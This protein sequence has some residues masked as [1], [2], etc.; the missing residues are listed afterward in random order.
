MGK[1]NKRKKLMKSK[2]LILSFVLICELNIYNNLV[3]SANHGSEKNLN[4]NKISYRKLT[5]KDIENIHNGSLYLENGTLDILLLK[6]NF[7][8]PNADNDNDGLKNDEEINIKIINGKEYINYISHPMLEDTDGDGINDNKDKEKL[9][10]NISERDMILFQE[11]CYRNDDYIDEV[12]TPNN[13]SL[14]LYKGREE[15]RL[16]NNELSFYWKRIKSWHESNGFDAVLFEY[17]NKK[18]PFLNNEAVHVLAIRGTEGNSDYGSDASIFLGQWPSQANSAIN[19][20]DEFDKFGINNVYV[21]GHSL[22]G[23]LGQVFLVRSLGGKYTHLN[24]Y[25]K[26]KKNNNNIKELFTWNAPPIKR[27]A[28]SYWM[29]EYRDIGNILTKEKFAKHYSVSNDSLIKPIGSFEGTIF[30]GNSERGHSSRSFFE[31]KFKNM[32]GFS[33]GNRYGLSSKGYIQNNLP[34]INFQS[35]KGY[36][37]PLIKDQTVDKNSQPNAG[38]SIAN[39]DDLPKGTNYEWKTPIDTTTPGEKDGVVVVKYPDG[40][41]EEV[42]VKVTVKDDAE[43]NTP[44]GQ[45]QTVNKGDKPNAGDSI[46]NKDDLPKGTNYEWKTPIDTTTPGEKDGV[47]VVKYPDG[48]SEEV[49][50]KVTVTNPGT[51]ADNY[52]PQGKDQTVD[53]NSQPNAGDSIA[54]KDD[55]PK[56]TNYEWK[57]PID[58]TTPGEKDGVVVV[59]YPDGSSEEVPVKV[60]VTNPG[61]DADNYTPQGKDQTVNKGDKP[62]AGDSIANKDDLPKGTNYEWKT[63]IDTTTPGEK[64]GVVVVKYPD[65]SSEEVPVKVTVTNPGT[66]AEMNTPQGQDQTVNKGDKPNA[67]DSIANKD[68]LP[69]GTNYEWKTPI[70]TT[71]P[72][73]KDGVVVVKYPDG[74]SEEVPVK[75]TVKDDAEMNTPQGQDQTVDKNSQPNAG[76]SIANKDDLPKGTNYEWK[77]PIDTTT[78]GEKDGV[79]VVKYPDGSSEEV[80]V[81]VTVKDDAEMNTPQGQDQ[82]VNKGDKPNAGDSIANKDDLPKGT[83]YEWKTPIDTT[84]PGEKDGV[85][86]VK[87]PDGSSEEVPVKVT[88]KDDAEMNTPQGQDQTVNKGDKPN[89][90]DSIANKDDLPKGTNYEWKTPIDTTTPGEKDGVVVVKYPDGSSEEVPVKVTVKDDAEMN[91]PQGQDQTVNKGDKPNAGDS[92]ANKDDL[93][94][95]TN[96]EWK[97]PIDTTTPGEKDGVVVVKYPDGSSEEV[98]VKVTVKDDAEMNT[99]Q[100]Q[101]QT[102]DKNSQPNAGDSIANKD[103]LPK[104]T[105]YEWK[106]PIDTTT[107]GEKD[108]VVVVKYPDGSSEEVPVKVTVKDDAEMNTPQG[109]DQTVDKNSQPNA[110]DSI[111]NKDDLPKGTNYEWKTPIDTTTP[112]EKDGVVVVKY[113]DGSSEEVPVKVTVKDDAEMNTPQGQDQTVDKNSQPNAGDSIANKDDLPKGTNYEWKTPIDTTTPGE[114]DG[115]VVVKYPDGS[116]EEVPV[117]VTVKDDAE[118]NTPQ[119]QD[120]TVN[121]GDKPNAGDSIANKDDLPKGTNYEWKTPIDTTTPGEKDGVVVV[122]Y[123]DGS[124][125]EVPVKVTVKD[126]AEMNTPQG[127]DQTVNKGDKPNAG[128]SIAN[129]DDLPKGTNYEWKTPIDTTTPGEKDG[130]VVVKYPDGSSEEVP[131]KVTVTNPGTDAD[132]YTP[133]GKDQTV[134]KNSQPN[135]GDSIANKDDLPKG[136][137]Y[138]WKTPIDTTTPGEK[139]GVVVVKYPDGSSEEVPVKVTVTNPGTDADN[140]TP[141]GKDQT[142]NKGDKPNAGDSIAN[143]DD[144]PKG[145]NYEWKTPIDTTTPGEKDGVVVVKYP[146]GSS[147]EVPVKVTVTNPGTDAEMNTPQGK[148]QT[149]NKGDKPNAGDSIANK[150]DL[151]KGTNYE[152]KTPIDTTTPGEKDGV[153]VVKYPD[154]S[155]EEVPVKVTVKDDAEMNTPQGQDQTVNKGDKPNA[156]DSIANKD[157]LPKGTNYEWKTPIDTTTPG[158]KDG[159]V[160]VKYPD[161]SSEEVPVKVTVTNPGTDADNYT[162]QGK[163]Q[164]VNKGDKPNAGDSIANKDDLPKGTNYEWKTPIDTTTPG[165]KDG[166]VVVKY[167]DGSSEEV[168]VKVTVT[169]PGTDADN[170]TPQGKDQTVDKNSQPNA[171][172]SIA[173]KDDLPKG[174][175]YEWKTPIDTTTPG[176][177]DGVV[178]VKY[179]DGS[180]E[181]V[182]VKVTVTNPGTDADNYTPQGKDQIVNKG[183]KPNAG[184]SIAN[185]DDLPK[186]TNYEWK[187]PIDTTTPGEKDGV[188]VVKYPDGSSEEV[189]VKV[190]VTNPGTDADNYTPQGKDQTVNKGDKPNAGDSIANKDDLPKGTNYE[191]KTP[192]DTTTPGEKDG[193]VVVKYPDGSSE[194]VPVKVTVTNPGT[195]ADNYTPQGKDQTVNKGDKP[196]A[197]DSIA[198]KDDLPKGTNYEWKTPIDTTTPGEKDGVVVVKYPDGSSEEVPVKV[199]VKDDAEMNTPQGQDQTVNKGDKPNAGD[200]IA[201]KDDLPKGTNY[202]WKTPIDTTTPGEKDGVVVVKYP[203][204]SSEEVPVKVTVKDDAEMNTPQGQDQT[205]DKNSQ[206]NAGD[207]IANKDDLPKGTN[208][209]WKTPIDTTTPGEKDGVVVVKYPDGSSEEVPVK[210]TVKDD[211]EMNTP[212]GQDQTVDKN[213]Q[214]NAGDSI[215]NKDDLPKGTNYEWKTPIDTTT[216]GEKDGVVVVKYPD[217]SSEEVPV[218]VTVKDDAEMN[219][220]QGQDQTVDKNSQPN[221]GNSIANKDDLPKGTNYEWKTPI[222]TTT[223]G[224]KVGVVVVKYPDGSSEEVPVKVTVGVTNPGTDAD[225]YTPQGKD[226]IVNKGDKPNAGDSIANKDDLPKGTNYEW[227]TPIDTTTP[228]EKVGVV[229]VKYPDGSSEEVPVKVT[230]GVTNP[231]TDADNYTPQGQDQ[232]VDK[233]SQPNAG[234]SIANKDDLPKGTNYEWKTPIDTTTPGEKVGVVVVKYPDGSSEEVPVKV[235]VGVTNPGTNADNYTPQGKDQTVNKD[236][237][238]LPKTGDSRIVGYLSLLIASIIGLF[239]NKKNKE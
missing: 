182:P 85:V 46:A 67:G 31:D 125:E 65:G 145:T 127:Q 204:G 232:T 95:G 57:T 137:N 191:W 86:V 55:L 239:F 211:A 90:G 25:D 63:P 60:T 196:N 104:G 186:G 187:T 92:I 165:E 159:V 229:V 178:V 114:K 8:D 141:Q 94:K 143:K 163:D 126:D 190:T 84:T 116:S 30:I 214:P 223:P 140:Y 174:T 66:D 28:F 213:S 167:P 199:T 70:D 78:P 43:M 64:D 200:S 201:N 89:A 56:G 207:S 154:G 105:N 123:P 124:S 96:Y 228:G 120:Q 208:Y 149:V 162:P 97:T 61:T 175:N 139:D 222:D 72:G 183:D 185:K 210:V 49:P 227:K 112:G 13:E 168:P 109:Q 58:T 221:A 220:P 106:T 83:N 59:K 26:D 14:T 62:N 158:E 152:W 48:S 87:Y 100:G 130:V 230:V 11:L 195:D 50:V 176:E 102:V 1:N 238:S 122:K 108:G 44:Q 47:V 203:D 69:K 42:P 166:V 202:E 155:S 6:K 142:V 235:T 98:P 181:E 144:L 121:K 160:V 115:V 225:N 226:Q 17:S 19:L 215:A 88:V 180:S 54:N 131:V 101:D 118:M 113:P 212:Q 36:Y 233:N 135:A 71:T 23:F 192:I 237:L 119:G 169:N 205:V 129:K 51:D 53:K 209:E 16:M 189:P 179:P 150:D 80:P 132:N 76:D 156:G 9:T 136:T 4:L 151:P 164:T 173:N 194:E 7:N 147:E 170:Y 184:D 107:P 22:G 234:D 37:N 3:Y 224:E 10:W 29:G 81:K 231:G 188:V 134:D 193:V 82:T 2:P 73:E 236:I 103:D 197:G 157:D 117:K 34:F 93:P 153:V 12:L 91:T 41:S 40:S 111:A 39:K 32:P 38:N 177:K 77:T 68:D 172:D 21:T 45:D 217:G 110:G 5:S 171:G 35:F 219:T 218:K 161:G 20:A 206:P 74:S 52:T 27:G 128:D 33:V 18:I 138:E 198:N 216:P 146:D 15:Y 148:D 75:V 24:K 99:P 133:Q 79:V